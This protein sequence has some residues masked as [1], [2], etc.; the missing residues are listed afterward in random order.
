MSTTGRKG[1]KWKPLAWTTG[2]SKL[3]DWL[4]CQQGHSQGVTAI[5]ALSAWHV[6]RRRLSFFFKDTILPKWPQAASTPL[7]HPDLTNAFQR[8]QL[9]GLGCVAFSHL[10]LPT[11]LTRPPLLTSWCFAQVWAQRHC[12][13]PKGEG[14]NTPEQAQEEEEG[15]APPPE[16]QPTLAGSKHNLAK[17]N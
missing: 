1:E 17:P 16:E 10:P 9:N 8:L 5:R 13:A 3:D 14:A 12:P 7:Q 6:E 2:C 11:P 15:G 4:L